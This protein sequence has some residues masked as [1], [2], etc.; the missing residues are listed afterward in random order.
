M[1]TPLAALTLCSIL[2]AAGWAGP[3]VRGGAGKGTPGMSSSL[4]GGLQRAIRS[5]KGVALVFDQPAFAAF[6]RFQPESAFHQEVLG[7]MAAAL[8]PAFETEL[9]SALALPESEAK[10]AAVAG[11]LER[12][13]AVHLAETPAIEAAVEARIKELVSPYAE[14]KALVPDVEAEAP[15]LAAFAAYGAVREKVRAVLEMARSIHATR[16]LQ[17]ARNLAALLLEESQP[18]AEKD[19]LVVARD[20]GGE[21]PGLAELVADPE[22]RAKTLAAA[23]DMLAIGHGDAIRGENLTD[24]SLSAVNLYRALG[25]SEAEIAARV[26]ARLD[27]F[28]TAGRARGLSLSPGQMT[29]P[30]PSVLK[31]IPAPEGAQAV[32]ALAAFEAKYRL[33]TYR[34]LRAKIGMKSGF[35]TDTVSYEVSL[36]DAFRLATQTRDEARAG[37]VFWHMLKL[38][39]YESATKAAYD[40]ARDDVLLHVGFLALAEFFGSK[41][42]GNGLWYA[43]EALK[44]VQGELKREA[45]EVLFD[46]SQLLL[47]EELAARYPSMEN[48]SYNGGFAGDALKALRATGRLLRVHPIDSSKDDFVTVVEDP[49]HKAALEAMTRGLKGPQDEYLRAL[50]AIGDKEAILAYARDEVR[51]GRLYLSEPMFDALVVASGP[52]EL[53][54]FAAALLAGRATSFMLETPYLDAARLYA[55]A[56]DLEGLAGVRRLIAADGVT[57]RHDYEKLL[58]AYERLA[59]DGPVEPAAV[60]PA[61]EDER[62]KSV[63]S[64]SRELE[65][66]RASIAE[67]RA[68]TTEESRAEAL[69]AGRDYLARGKYFEASQQFAQALDRDGLIASA[70]GMVKRGDGLNARRPYLLAALLRS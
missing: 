6:A 25:L 63:D 43:I 67:T 45:A 52:E 5:E 8:G 62:E 23:D 40:A 59:A 41:T 12:A 53:R 18:S 11:L 29:L 10:T 17:V 35:S 46:L 22:L 2:A 57:L 58:R 42:R 3:V 66:L 13:A 16:S 65:R 15:E 51:R 50:A 38:G 36:M 54:E 61:P 69:R 47:S 26:G 32:S 27:Q 24:W 49:K 64:I 7:G 20:A 44:R 9:L 48:G 55:A 37:E 21:N 68:T 4:L 56:R 60:V 31:S 70:D 19:A 28:L 39:G 34:G 14:G 33:E 30:E 1:R